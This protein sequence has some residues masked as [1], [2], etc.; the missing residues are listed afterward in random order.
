MAHAD[1]KT[2]RQ[3]RQPK[4][5]LS[6][7]AASNKHAAD[8]SPRAPWGARKV[9][10]AVANV[11][12]AQSFCAIPVAETTQCFQANLRVSSATSRS[13]KGAR[14]ELASELIR[15][16]QVRSG[17]QPAAKNRSCLIKHPPP[18]R[19]RTIPAVERV[20]AQLE[21]PSLDFRTYRVIRLRNGLEAYSGSSNAHT[22]DTSTNYHFEVS[23]KPSNDEEPT[24]E[25]PSPLHGAL[26]RFA[27]FFVEPLFLE[28]TLNR[29]LHAVNSE[30]ENNLQ[31]D[32][33]RLNQLERSISNPNHPFGHFGTG[34]L[35]TLKNQ[36]EAR[37][38]NVRDKFIEFYE[39]HYSAN[40]MKLC[41][42]GREPLDVLESWVCEYFSANSLS[43][44][45]CAVCPGSPGLFWVTISLTEE[46]LENYTEVVKVVFQYIAILCETEPQQWIFDEQQTM[47]DIDFKFKED[48]SSY[49]FTIEISTVMQRPLPREWL[50]SGTQ[51]LRKFDA[52]L[53][54]EAL[55][56]LRSDNFRLSIVSKDLPGTW[57]K[58]EKCTAGD[59]IPELHLPHKNQ[60]IP[61]TKLEVEKKEVEEP[62]AAPHIIRNEEFVR[63]WYKKDDA[64]WVPK[65]ML[66][67]SCKSPI[68]FLSARNYTMAKIYTDLV[69]DALEEHS[70]DALLTGLQYDVSPDSQ[71][72][73]IEVSGY[74]DKLHVLLDKVLITM[75]DL[76]TRNDRFDIIKEQLTRSYQN[77]ELQPPWEQIRHYLS[78]LAVEHHYVAEELAAELPTIT[79]EDVRVFHKDLLG[80]LYMELYAHGNLYKE[81]ALNLTDLVMKTLKPGARPR[82][83]RPIQRLLIFPPGSNYVW[84]KTLKDMENVNHCI[85]YWLYL[86]SP[87]WR[88]R[89]RNDLWHLLYQSAK[90]APYLL[91]TRIEL[92]LETLFETIQDMIEFFRQSIH[93]ASPQRAKLAI[94]F[95]A[96]AKSDDGVV[97]DAQ[98][99]PSNGTSP[100]E[101][102]DVSDFKSGLT[103]TG[104]A[105][106]VTDLSEFE[107][108]M[109]GHGVRNTAH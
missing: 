76:E 97:K 28:S 102:T 109:A 32:G 9:Y 47:A 95:I 59:R 21:T 36:P 17:P 53:S 83:Q 25:N 10:A 44:G 40:L 5:S 65:T 19:E 86:G 55:G 49:K 87:I 56:Y 34:N 1:P 85:N 84:K 51:R 105:C 93:P 60:F 48:T 18:L 8:T 94:H 61:T 70:Y 29:E 81:D 38:I 13:L 63:T 6:V 88:Q 2:T 22:D 52:E 4:R 100:I 50:L 41:V 24:A 30:N 99:R 101:I 67:V 46:G 20:T 91:E 66:T 7:E 3:R 14:R 62:A 33:W 80:Q 104:G 74:D 107:E 98:P 15:S 78:W 27:Q 43:A 77:C 64:F 106:P 72:L 12:S 71:G 73:L 96:Q 90:T 75:R 31:S 82:E 69:R 39:E 58:R 23:A 42:L 68:I 45:A 108:G 89:Q 11:V 92:F 79:A 54:K 37:G 103:V 57:N 26:D 35:E 16:F